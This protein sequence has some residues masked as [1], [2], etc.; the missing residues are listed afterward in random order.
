[1]AREPRP[2]GIE[3]PGY[4]VASTGASVISRDSTAATPPYT[5]LYGRGWDAGSNVGSKAGSNVNNSHASHKKSKNK[6]SKSIK[7]PGGAV[8]D[9]GRSVTS[10]SVSSR[11]T[12]VYMAPQPYPVY[13]TIPDD[14]S[15]AGTVSSR[16]TDVTTVS[17]N[18]TTALFTRK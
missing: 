7:M 15:E 12:G 3:N 6:P 1:M 17:L 11:A 2:S 13:D 9:D 14:V 18:S 4:L 8:Y 5:D 16:A 10:G